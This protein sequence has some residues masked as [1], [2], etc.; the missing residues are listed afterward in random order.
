MSSEAEKVI[1]EMRDKEKEMTGIEKDKVYRV[2][3]KEDGFEIRETHEISESRL[4][5]YRCPHC[6]EVQERLLITGIRV[7]GDNED[8]ASLLKRM[9][10][11]DSVKI[12]RTKC[13]YCGGAIRGLCVAWS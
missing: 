6:G 7:L 11:H 2:T 4:K 9:A 3:F 8:E 10:H 13:D 5:K 1:N 12:I